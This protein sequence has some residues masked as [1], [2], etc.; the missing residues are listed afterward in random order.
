MITLY[1]DWPK[2]QQ[3]LYSKEERKA[4]FNT[5]FEDDEPKSQGCARKQGKN[6]RM[7]K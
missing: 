2:M 4:F 7:S 3:K 5:K 1:T 6:D